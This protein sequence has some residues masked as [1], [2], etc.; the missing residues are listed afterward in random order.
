MWIYLPALRKTRRLVSSDRSKRFMG[1]EFSNDDMSIPN[2]DDFQFKKIGFATIDEIE[3]YKIESLPI[4][5]DIADDNGFSKKVVYIEKASFHAR[6][7]DYYD[8]E[9]KLHKELLIS[10]YDLIDEKNNKFIARTL[11]IENK[12]NGRKSIMKLEKVML[13]HQLTDDLFTTYNLEK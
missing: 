7:V 10:D 3:C 13:N 9:G 2:L 11:E 12:Q 8:L 1:S 6:R 4:S 5:E